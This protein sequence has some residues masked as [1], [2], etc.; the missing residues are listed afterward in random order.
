MSMS[1]RETIPVILIFMSLR[2]ALIDAKRSKVLMVSD[3]WQSKQINL[4]EGQLA[5][6]PDNNESGVKLSNEWTIFRVTIL[7]HRQST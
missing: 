4:L 2:S 6:S 7:K 3:R 5:V 1:T